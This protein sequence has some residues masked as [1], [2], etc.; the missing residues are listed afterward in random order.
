MTDPTDPLLSIEQI[1]RVWK[2]DTSI[3]TEL[4]D[5][6]SLPTLDGGASA[7]H[8]RLDVPCARLSWAEGLRVDS[9]GAVRRINDPHSGFMHAAASIAAELHRALAVENIDE[10]WELSTQES[11]AEGGSRA[12]LWAR[13]RA[14]LPDGFGDDVAITTGVYQLLP[15]PGVGVRL[16]HSIAPVPHS[17]DRA[18]P[19]P[20]AGLIPM[21][22][23]DGAWRAHL[24][25]AE[26]DVEWFSLLR[27][28]PDQASEPGS[29]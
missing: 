17:H 6:G 8:G 15:H 22:R 18:T 26:L 3:V 10:V 19:I 16:V 20:S 14:A 9:P 23:E 25:L 21:I 28:A 12:G 5:D 29:N 1:A 7:Q 27:T 2:V 24:P 4:V 13:W 11:R